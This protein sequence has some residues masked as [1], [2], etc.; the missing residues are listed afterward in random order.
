MIFRQKNTIFF[1]SC[2][3]TPLNMYNGLSQVIVSNQKDKSISI[4]WFKSIE[5]E[6]SYQYPVG[7]L[8]RD[9]HFVVN[10]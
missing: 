1:E 6:L 7:R 8:H 4:Q 10:N 5:N 3:L 2:N 9:P